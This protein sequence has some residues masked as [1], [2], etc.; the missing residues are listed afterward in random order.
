VVTGFVI[1]NV[2]NCWIKEQ[3]NLCTVHMSAGE[4]VCCIAVTEKISKG[5]TVEFCT[6]GD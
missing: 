4:A 3:I 6:S 2:K 1:I 5:E